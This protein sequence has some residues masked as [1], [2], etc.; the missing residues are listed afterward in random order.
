MVEI[1][2]VLQGALEPEMKAPEVNI[3]HWI[4]PE[5]L[6]EEVF[7]KRKPLRLKED[8]DDDFVFPKCCSDILT[9]ESWQVSRNGLESRI[10]ETF[11]N[12]VGHKITCFKIFIFADSRVRHIEG[13]A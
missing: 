4:K 10:S 8:N 6:L 9:S 7:A 5:S 3:P 1:L 13:R 2:N 11:D 12:K